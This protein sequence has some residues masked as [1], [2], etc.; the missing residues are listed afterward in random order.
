MLFVDLWNQTYAILQQKFSVLKNENSTSIVIL[1]S[2]LEGNPP[3]LI[4]LPSG[5]IK[6]AL[7]NQSI[8]IAMCGL[9]LTQGNDLTNIELFDFTLPYYFSGMQAVV[10]LST[11]EPSLVAVMITIFSTI[12][13]K[14]Q[15]ILVTLMLFVILFGHLIAA[16]ENISRSS[17]DGEAGQIRNSYFEGTQDGM[18]YSTVIMSTGLC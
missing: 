11:D 18:W 17:L 14:A 16:A 7:A 3:N 13:A 2:L 8:D 6:S 5:S 1:E 4:L 9:L 15:L 12:D 10:P